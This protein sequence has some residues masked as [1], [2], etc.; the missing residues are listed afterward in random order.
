MMPLCPSY[1][2]GECDNSRDKAHGLACVKQGE[3]SS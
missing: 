3:A 2:G 1:S